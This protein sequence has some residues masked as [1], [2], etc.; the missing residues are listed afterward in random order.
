VEALV[1]ERREEVGEVDEQCNG[2]EGEGEAVIVLAV[3]KSGEVVSDDGGLLKVEEG[4]EVDDAFGMEVVELDEGEPEEEGEEGDGGE[5][6]HLL[7]TR[8]E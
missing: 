5:G 4:E 3:E 6:E 2:E 7:F 8:S 1:A